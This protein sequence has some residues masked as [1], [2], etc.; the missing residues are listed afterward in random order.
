MPRA[1]ATRRKPIIEPGETPTPEQLAQGGYERKFVTHVE[2]GTVTTAHISAHSPVQR[3]KRAGRLSDS[4]I[5]AIAL[6]EAL[7]A[8]CGLRQKLT[9]SYGERMPMG[10]D[11]EWLNNTEIDARRRLKRIEG[12]V[13]AHMWEPFENVVR[14]GE[15]SGTAGASLG[16]EGSRS[17]QA[18]VLMLCMCVADIIAR[19]ERL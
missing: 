3:W 12:Y 4:Q 13:P 17:A 15:P 14:H 1:R 5:D 11:N 9:A 16:F 8:K 18:A 19:E 6:C 2:T 10:C 7:W